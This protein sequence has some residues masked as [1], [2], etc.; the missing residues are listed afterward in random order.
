[1][2]KIYQKLGWND[3]G[4]FL[5]RLLRAHVLK[6]SAYFENEDATEKSKELFRGFMK[7]KIEPPKHVKEA[8]FCTGIKYS[9]PKQWLEMLNLSLNAQP[10]VQNVIWQSL[11]CSKDLW[12]LKSFVEM[13]LD[14]KLIRRSDIRRVYSYYGLTALSRSVYFDFI[15][16]NWETLYKK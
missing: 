11:V 1:L 12:V 2:S 10:A 16:K 7:S 6:Y 3:E 15:M 13:T 4:T 14:E 5:E 8:A 9:N